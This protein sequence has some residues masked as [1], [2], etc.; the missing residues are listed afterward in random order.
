VYVFID[1]FVL[2]FLVR[3]NAM[4]SHQKLIVFFCILYSFSY[5]KKKWVLFFHEAPG[6]VW[7]E[8][9]MVAFQG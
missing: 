9:T 2:Y 1:F 4:F 6:A 8:A 5:K 3:L 7:S